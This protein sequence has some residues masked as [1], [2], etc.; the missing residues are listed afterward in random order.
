MRQ[1]EHLHRRRQH[2]NF[3]EKSH[4][5]GQLTLPIRDVDGSVDYRSRA[6]EDPSDGPSH[7]D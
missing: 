5:K 1:R 7:P 3:P 4:F 6:L 2:Y